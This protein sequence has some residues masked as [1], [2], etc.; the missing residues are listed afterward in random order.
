[1]KNK[2]NNLLHLPQLKRG[3]NSGFNQTLEANSDKIKNNSFL[4]DINL[5]ELKLEIKNEELQAIQA[6]LEQTLQRYMSLYEFAPVGYLII[7]EDE[8][9]DEANLTS[10]KFLGADRTKILNQNLRKYIDPEDISR[11]HEHFQQNV[12][13]GK[14][15]SCELRVIP[16]SGNILYA[17]FD[18]LIV[19]LGNSQY[20]DNNKMKIRVAIT[21]V[22]DQKLAE[23]DLH[24][25]ASIFHSKQGMMVL[26]ANQLILKVNVAFTE[27]TGYKL[28]DLVG[29]SPEILISDKYDADF[30]DEILSDIKMNGV[31]QGEMST[32]RKNGDTFP[33]W[34]NIT[35]VK[36]SNGL[37]INYVA[38]F[39]DISALKIAEN[40]MKELAF[41][42]PLTMLPNRRLMLDRI[43]QGIAASGRSQQYYAL[44]FIDLDH[45]KA[46]NDSLGHDIGDLMLQAISQRLSVCVREG[47]TVARIG[48]DEFMVMLENLSKS[49]KNSSS[50]AV[51]VGNKILSAIDKPFQLAGHDCRCSASIGLTIFTGHSYS[52]DE[53]KKQADIAMYQAKAAGRNMLRIFKIDSHY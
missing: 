51:S 50:L 9:I 1:M 46:L 53:L 32:L 35:A 15:I 36:N 4:N 31:W 21:D 7:S 41:Y 40:E 19:D 13:Q 30:Y 43:N 29:K 45:F 3:L 28:E 5:H 33:V 47:D 6:N 34:L 12:L 8:V 52:V 37:V 11:W 27:V 42:D 16:V 18:C 38:T 49:A 10:L 2:T 48:G 14:N 24:I 25:V 39:S 23:K 26:D 17:R 44:M 22:T 20:V